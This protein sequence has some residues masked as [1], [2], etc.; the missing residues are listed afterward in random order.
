MV[1][2]YLTEQTALR[3]SYWQLMDAMSEDWT[4]KARQKERARQ[5]RARHVQHCFAYIA[6]SIWCSAD[7]TIEWAQVQK[8]G[9]RRQVDGWGIPHQCKDPDA[10]QA[11]VQANHGPITREDHVHHHHHNHDGH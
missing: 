4:D 10:I 7:L 6:E 2:P 3:E 8:N 5:I 1:L 9:D 11:W